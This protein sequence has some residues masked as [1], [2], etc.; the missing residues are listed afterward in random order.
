MSQ[1]YFIN[2]IRNPSQIMPKRSRDIR[3]TQL[4]SKIQIYYN[5]P[6]LKSSNKTDAKIVFTT[7]RNQFWKSFLR[8]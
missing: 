3:T 4:V 1:F 7:L 5:N 6:N 2:N 8:R